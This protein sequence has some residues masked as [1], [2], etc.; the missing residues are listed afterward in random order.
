MIIARNFTESEVVAADEKQLEELL[1]QRDER[2]GAEFWLS[3]DRG[4][5]PCL[6]IVVSGDVSFAIYFPEEGHPGF[7]CLRPDVDQSMVDESTNFVWT[8]CDPASGEL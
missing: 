7:R 4:G 2:G 1:K 3:D 8:G 5:F 6:T